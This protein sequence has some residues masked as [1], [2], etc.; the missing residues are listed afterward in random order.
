M[1]Q[2]A[3]VS[4]GAVATWTRPTGPALPG[5]EGDSSGSVPVVRPGP[6]YPVDVDYWGAV[7]LGLSLA[8]VLVYLL[9][10]YMKKRRACAR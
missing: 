5:T 1:L 9:V 10:F 8:V 6:G 3:G 2:I 7:L 4:A